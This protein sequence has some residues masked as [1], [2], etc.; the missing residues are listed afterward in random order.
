MSCTGCPKKNV[1]VAYCSSSATAT[2]FLG[3]PVKF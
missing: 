1:A 2:F 3:H